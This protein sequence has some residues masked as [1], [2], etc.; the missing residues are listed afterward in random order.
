VPPTFGA[1]SFGKL[2]QCQ[3]AS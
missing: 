3:T 2:R 1:A